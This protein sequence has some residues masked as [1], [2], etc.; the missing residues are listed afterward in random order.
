MSMSPRAPLA[1]PSQ[2]APARRNAANADRTADSEHA[3]LRVVQQFA[4]NRARG[5]RL[6]TADWF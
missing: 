1:R 3:I 5:S 2:A 6:S 4:E